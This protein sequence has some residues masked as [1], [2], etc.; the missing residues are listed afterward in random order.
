MNR[1]RFAKGLAAILAIPSLAWAGA[2]PPNYVKR[3]KA[4]TTITATGKWY[5]ATAVCDFEEQN[6]CLRM[7]EQYIAVVDHKVDEAWRNAEIKMDFS[8][9]AYITGFNPWN[10]PP[11]GNNDPV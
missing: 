1:R 9:P 6:Q 7:L 5:Y 2:K 10:A 8:G 3:P 4:E 11:T